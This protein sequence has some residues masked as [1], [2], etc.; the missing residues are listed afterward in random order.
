MPIV[1]Y[2]IS[3]LEIGQVNCKSYSTF[4]KEDTIM[5]NTYFHSK[6]KDI[7]KGGN[8]TLEHSIIP[9]QRRVY[10]FKEKKEEEEEEFVELNLPIEILRQNKDRNSFLAFWYKLQR[11]D[12]Q[13]INV[14]L[15]LDNDGNG[16][17]DER[18]FIPKQE[19]ADLPAENNFQKREINLSKFSPDIEKVRYIIFQLNKKDDIEEDGWH[20]F[21]IKDDIVIFRK[22]PG[23]IKTDELRKNLL[24]ELNNLDISILN[25]DQQEFKFSQINNKSWDIFE[26]DIV[27]LG[28]CKLQKGN[29]RINLLENDT[30]KTEWAFVEAVS[31][32]DSMESPIQEPEIIFKKINQ[33]KYIIEI[34]EAKNPFWLVFLESF[35]PQWKIFFDSRIPAQ[36][37]DIVKDYENL[38]VKEARY[39]LKFNPFDLKYLFA[40]PLTNEHFLVNLYA[41][42]WYIDPKKLDLPEEFSLVL[43]F[44]PQYL[45]N[46][47]LIIAGVTL[48]L[49]LVYLMVIGFI[50]RNVKHV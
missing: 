29:H 45:Y 16:S 26:G 32:E 17:I 30:F 12:V 22:Y 42:G 50:K 19:L 38:G 11:P 48:I 13:E 24:S 14:L 31:E 36:E 21:Y 49:S 23:I 15:G 25:I 7:E 27:N 35:H 9:K 4:L 28:N 40:K 18:I 34:K 33:A 37:F 39:Q 20:T 41:N 6:K 43:Y 3:D 8:F 46:I 44:W 47:G 1:K 2:K 5:I 10:L